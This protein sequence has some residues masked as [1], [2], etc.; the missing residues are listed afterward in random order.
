[1]SK[2]VKMCYAFYRNSQAILDNNNGDGQEFYFW[3][4][5]HQIIRFQGQKEHFVGC[6]V[7]K[8]FL[9]RILEVVAFSKEIHQM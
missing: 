5:S 2:A 7:Y 4:H 8:S 1:M 6:N 9:S 3:K